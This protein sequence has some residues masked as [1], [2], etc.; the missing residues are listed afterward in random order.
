MNLTLTS[1]RGIRPTNY[2]AAFQKMKE[3]LS[4]KEQAL[5]D[6]LLK[7]ESDSYWGIAIR[8]SFIDYSV[9]K[10]RELVAELLSQRDDSPDMMFRI[11]GKVAYD[12]LID[13]K[14]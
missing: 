7:V 1:K 10:F 11:L 3:Q 14:P 13:I 8:N 2:Y 9:M 5:H 4:Q 12:C 6:A